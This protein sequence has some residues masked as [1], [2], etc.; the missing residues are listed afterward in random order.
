MKDFDPSKLIKVPLDEVYPNSWNPKS[1]SKEYQKVV[2]SIIENGY[3]SPIAV[4]EKE[5]GYEIIDGFHRWKALRELGYTEAYV[6]NLGEVDDNEAK[7]LTIWFEVQVPFDEIELAPMVCYLHSINMKVPYSE[8]DLIRFDKM[9]SF[10]FD[11]FGADQGPV[12]DDKEDEAPEEEE[13]EKPDIKMKK[14]VVQMDGEQLDFVK[15]KIKQIVKDEN[16]SDG[17]ALELIVAD[18]LSGRPQ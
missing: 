4:R 3:I 14:L 17:R 18:Y 16:V 13:E 15:N 12:L 9:Q 7:S 1:E 5:D 10:S 8:D 6:Y 2:D 11:D